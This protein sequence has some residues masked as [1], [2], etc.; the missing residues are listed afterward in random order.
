MGQATEALEDLEC[1]LE[2]LTAVAAWFDTRNFE[3][4]FSSLFYHKYLMLVLFCLDVILVLVKKDRKPIICV[5][6]EDN[7]INNETLENY[8]I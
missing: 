1:Q 8:K 6:T 2:F 3:T 5:F 7:N 4:I